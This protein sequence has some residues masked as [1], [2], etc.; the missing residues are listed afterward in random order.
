MLLKV[1]TRTENNTP[2]CDEFIHFTFSINRQIR[3]HKRFSLTFS[4]SWGTPMRKG[5]GA[6]R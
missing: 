5:I 4:T 3:L 1:L 6:K 2:Q